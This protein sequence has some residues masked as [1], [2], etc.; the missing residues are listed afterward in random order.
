[1]L[2]E[3]LAACGAA[4]VDVAWREVLVA[5]REVPEANVRI[6]PL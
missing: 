2:A 1:V 3:A 5:L 4:L 6:S